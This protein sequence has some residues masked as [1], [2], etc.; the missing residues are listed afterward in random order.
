MSESHA[1][2]ILSRIFLELGGQI[3]RRF[4]YTKARDHW[5]SSTLSTTDFFLFIIYNSFM[6]SDSRHEMSQVQCQS[7][8]KIIRCWHVLFLSSPQD[9]SEKCLRRLN[10]KLKRPLSRCWEW[11]KKIICIPMWDFY[12]DHIQAF[13]PLGNFYGGLRGS[14]Q[15]LPGQC[16][17]MCENSGQFLSGR[18]SGC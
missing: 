12:P 13:Q 3:Q 14:G 2:C 8:R 5:S 18:A 1:K 17:G 6:A 9:W 11:R 10:Q 16:W 15:F 7:C 4:I